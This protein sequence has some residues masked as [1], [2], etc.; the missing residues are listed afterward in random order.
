MILTHKHDQVI[1]VALEPKTSWL[2]LEGPAQTGKSN[3]AIFLFGLRVADSDS[4][5]HCIA[6]RDLDA[7]RDNILMGEFKLLDLFGELMEVKQDKIG[8][9][10]IEFTTPKGIK[11]IL[12]AGYNDK[13]KWKKILGK[14]IECWFIDEINIASDTFVQE[15][16]ART[17][18]FDN[19]FTVC[20][21][22][23]DDPDHYIY[24][25]YINECIDLFPNDTPQPTVDQMNVD[26]VNGKYYAFWGLDDHPKMT[27]QKKERIQ[28]AYPQGSFYYMTK[29]LGIRGIQEGLLFGHLIKDKHYVDWEQVNI[30]AIHSLEVGIDIGDKALTVFTLTGYSQQYK[31]VIVIDSYAF[32]EA[33]YDEIIEKF[34]EWFRDWYYIFSAKVKCIYPDNADSIF[35]RTL[36][37]RIG[38]HVKVKGSIKSPIVDRVKLIEQLIHNDRLLFVRDYGAIDTA[39]HLKKLKSDGKGGVIDDNLPEND[40]WDSFM[41]GVTPHIKKLTD[42]V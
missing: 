32:N 12:L 33:D 42:S 15:H 2:T 3:L 29:V 19:P 36:R 41:Y 16:I 31:R 10:Y 7:I 25:D 40:Y 38:Y 6:A 8:G 9:Y 26:K 14:P 28:G 5:L 30:N 39:K 20:T 18:S 13:T 24:Q 4:E 34:N 35:V 22:N 1:K 21:L 37:K 27:P 23:G 11:R 17:F